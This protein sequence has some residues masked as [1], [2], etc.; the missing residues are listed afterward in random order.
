MKRRLIF[1]IGLEKTG[2]DSFQRFCAEQHESLRQAGTLYP[3]R[4][5][6]FG[7]YNHEPLVACYLDYH[8]FSIRSSGYARADVLRSLMAEIDAAEVPNVLIS[9]EHFSSRFREPEIERLAADF[10]GFDCRIAVVVREHRGRLY[11]AYSQAVLSGRD[12]T[13]G[14]Y[15]DEVFDPAN[16]YM[17]YGQTIG[18]WE[19]AFGRDTVVVF[20][21]S[22]GQDIIPVLCAALIAA[23]LPLS[24]TR[25][26]WDN[27]SIGP[28]ATEWLR[29][30]NR[31]VNRL[32]A[33]SHPT[34]RLALRGT[35]RDL[36][37]ILA[38][39]AGGADKRRWRLSER[40]DQRLGEIA[41]ADNA[42]LE[43]RYGIRLE[44]ASGQPIIAT[45]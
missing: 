36:A 19:A 30:T 6:A 27:L 42:W 34:M 14:E 10:A 11:S 35:R 7:G 29:R 18:A 2:T 26:Y 1:H 37:R 12:M 22:S 33:A 31:A 40:D 16:R 4:S 21:H 44:D 15:C 23:D 25:A 24:D 38:N 13:L 8:D 20:R 28:R 41:K 17:R 9:G 45:Q 5:L 39:L 43:R 32:P 3:T